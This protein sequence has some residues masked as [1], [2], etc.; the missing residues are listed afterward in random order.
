MPASPPPLEVHLDGLNLTRA[1]RPVLKAI[2]W[3]IRPGERWVVMGENGAGKTQLLKV[4]AG[5][6]RSADEAPTLRYRFAGEWHRVPQAVKAHIAYLGPERQDKYQRYAWNLPARAVVATGLSATDLP[7]GPL[8]TAA[9]RRAGQA[10]AALGARALAARPFL[11]LSYGERRLVL[12]ARALIANPSLLL[13]DEVFTGLD[14]PHRARLARWLARQRGRRPLVLATHRIED[15][16]PRATHL[17][18]LRRGRIVYRGPLQPRRAARE[19]RAATPGS[20]SRPARRR[21]GLQPAA[22]VQLKNAQIFL[23]DRP[24]LRELGFTVR[25][26]EFW[27][28]HGGNGS[29]KTT[30]LRTLYGDYGVAR[31]GTLRRIGIGP[32]VPLEQFRRRTGFV[33]PH[34]Q[35]RYPRDTR[36]DA[37]VQSGRYASIGLHQ[38]GTAAGRLAARRMLRRLGLVHLARRELGE[39]SYGQAR[40]V[41][42]ARA[43]VAHPR[44]LLLDE[45]LDS[46]DAATRRRLL[47]LIGTLTHTGMAIVVGAHSIGDWRALASHEI[48]LAGGRARY[49]GPIR[50]EPRRRGR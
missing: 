45:P 28:V 24:V 21:S 30:L 35:S 18:I 11:E 42:F 39:L 31:G 12:L 48:E 6:V 20:V 22:L 38:T 49:S 32:G 14:A 43:L 15:I 4:L 26:H 37:V 36:V 46:V 34:L 7:L 2:R 44:L 13:L 25:A 19:L 10:L 1:G 17:L 29:G 9:R 40:R 27:V 23:E 16:P 47:A 41:L 33:A 5:I 8:S 3:R 50:P